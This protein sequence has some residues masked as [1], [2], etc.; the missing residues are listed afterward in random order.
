V[1]PGKPNK[2][3]SG[4]FSGIIREPLAG[5][6]A[7]LPVADTVRHTHASPRAAVGFLIHAAGL[8]R[9]Q[10][11]ARVSLAMPGVC[12]TVAEQIESLARIA[13][14]KVAARIRRE[15]DELVMR[16]VSGWSERFDAKRAAA[17]GFKAEATFDDIVH[18]HIE[19]ELG[20]KIAG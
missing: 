12:C 6:E 5:Q 14:P 19:D 2:A 8:T 11:G 17:L 9:E 20:G 16:I 4:F 7:V 10:L 13:G 15:P 1:R 18:A 3:A